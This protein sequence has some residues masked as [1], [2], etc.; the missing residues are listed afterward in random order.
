MPRT[1]REK[2]KSGIYHVMIRGANRQEIF[3]DEQDCL[4]FLEI[5]EIYKVKT[6]IKIYDC[7]LMNNQANNRDGS[8]D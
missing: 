5:L 6:E 8:F 4:R 7:C 1:A 2:N 3:H